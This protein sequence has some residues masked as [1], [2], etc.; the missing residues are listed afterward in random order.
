V[1]RRRTDPAPVQLVDL[2]FHQ[3]D[4]RR[5]DKRGAAQHECRQLEPK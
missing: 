2:I 5:Y 4:E 3:R 1:Q